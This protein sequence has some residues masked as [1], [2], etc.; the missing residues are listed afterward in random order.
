MFV[1]NKYYTWYTNIIEN[2]KNCNRKKLKSTDKDYVYLENHHIKPAS[3]FP[4]LSK[5]KN[6]L[7][8]L[9]AKE[10]FIC[11]LLLCKF[12][13]STSKYKMI[14]ALIKMVYCES[15]EQIRYKSR[16]YS[17]IRKLIVEKFFLQLQKKI[18]RE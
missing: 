12:T 7:V 5:D 18:P 15:K 10:H 8:L 1:Q 13:E 2:A 3:L 11:H 4:N 14:N 17:I 6:N 16:S 9:T